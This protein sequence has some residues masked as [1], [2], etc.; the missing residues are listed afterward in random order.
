MPMLKET[1]PH[2]EQGYAKLYRKTYAPEEYTKSVLSIVDRERRRWGLHRRERNPASKPARGQ[3]EFSLAE[4]PPPRR[5]K[6]AQA[7]QPH[8]GQMELALTA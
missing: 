7:P 1:Y 4:A 2:L 6:P 8:A 5:R 3:L